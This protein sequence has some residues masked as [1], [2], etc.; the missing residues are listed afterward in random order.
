MPRIPE[1]AGNNLIP[2]RPLRPDELLSN[3]KAML[4]GCMNPAHPG[5]MGHMD[6][7]PSTM[8]VFA[9][10]AASSANN[11]MLSLELSPAFSRLE[12]RLLRA[13]ARLFG[14]PEGSGGVMLGG[15]SLANLQ[16]ITVARNIAFDAHSSGIALMDKRPV[17]FASDAAHTSI[18]KAAMILGLGTNA[19]IQV[20]SDETGRMD[21]LHLRKCIINAR[22]TNKAPF[23]VVA[24]AGTTT[25]GNIDPL[26][27]IHALAKEHGLWLHIDAVFGGT[28]I[29]S[30][31]RQKLLAGIELA[32][33]ISFNPQKWLY[34]TKTC[35]MLLLRDTKVLERDFRVH[36]PYMQDPDDDFNLGE[37]TIQGTRY[38][39][40]LK[41]WLT[42]QSIGKTGFAQLIEGAFEMTEHFVAHVKSRPYF[43]LSSEPDLNVVCFRGTPEWIPEPEWDQ[44]NRDLQSWLLEKDCFLSLPRF[45]NAAWLRVIM[46]NPFTEKSMIDKLFAH[47]DEYV[48]NKYPFAGDSVADFAAHKSIKT[49]AE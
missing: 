18:Q 17:L 39:D 2:E 47:I 14:L 41:L 12:L 38:P 4:D 3:M 33:S 15:G 46:L 45:R 42:L 31:E 35:G 26:P 6:P 32:D 16:A 24:T 48:A 10:L 8:S 44:W 7:M 43:T 30:K 49:P 22:E 34:V 9:D 11:N 23:C 40:V 1:F 20:R 36:V 19:V 5:Y 29:M 21:P 27:E 25:T 37:I 13:F 28:L